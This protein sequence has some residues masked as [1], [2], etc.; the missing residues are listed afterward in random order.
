MV[1]SYLLLPEW[2]V[3]DSPVFARQILIL[4]SE[5]VF[6]LLGSKNIFTGNGDLGGQ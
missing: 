2:Y 6:I 1:R 5:D 3:L 4:F